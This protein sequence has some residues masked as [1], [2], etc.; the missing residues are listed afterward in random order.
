MPDHPKNSKGLFV[1]HMLEDGLS[2]RNLTSYTPHTSRHL[3]ATGSMIEV[4]MCTLRAVP[5]G[6][7][8]DADIAWA[9]SAVEGDMGEQYDIQWGAKTFIC[10]C[11]TFNILILTSWAAREP[12][13]S[14]PPGCP[15]LCKSLHAGCI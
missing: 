4:Q 3:A 5:T 13:L 2:V 14:C 10:Y 15:S 9:L 1:P 12:L 6:N 8:R 11:F 7:E